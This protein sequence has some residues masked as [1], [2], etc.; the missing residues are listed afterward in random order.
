MECRLAWIAAISLE[1]VGGLQVPQ[2]HRHG[3]LGEMESL[4]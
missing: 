1:D 3:L 2:P 4:W